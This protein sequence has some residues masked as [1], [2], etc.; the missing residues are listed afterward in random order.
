MS[1]AFDIS[2]VP[3]EAEDLN[4]DLDEETTKGPKYDCAEDTYPAVVT[5]IQKIQK[6]GKAPRLKLEVRLTAPAVKGIKASRFYDLSGKYQFLLVKA[7]AVF[8][9]TPVKD[10]DGKET[11][12]LKD[13][14]YKIMGAECMAHVKP[15]EFT[16][17]DGKTMVF[18]DIVELK[19]KEAAGS[20]VPF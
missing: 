9:V 11:L 6:E 19:P 14:Y 15:R 1:S 13:N 3:P 20:D 12:P 17:D 16:R 4:I 8:G 2:P 10:A 5:A 18:M 7:A